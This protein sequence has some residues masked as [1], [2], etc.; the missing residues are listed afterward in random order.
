M[1]PLLDWTYPV[2]NKQKKALLKFLLAGAA[3]LIIDKIKDV[4]E[5]KADE[6]FPDEPDQ[7][8]N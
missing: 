4:I 5:E 7:E 6:R 2:K 8:K 1:R 3:A